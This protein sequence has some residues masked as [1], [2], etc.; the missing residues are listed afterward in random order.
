MLLEQ[1]NKNNMDSNFQVKPGY[2]YTVFDY[3]NEIFGETVLIIENDVYS[4]TIVYEYGGEYIHF[5]GQG[6]FNQ[7]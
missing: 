1:V 2:H 5:S 6:Y 4:G 7:Q 3:G